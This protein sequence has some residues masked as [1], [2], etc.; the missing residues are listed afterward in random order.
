MPGR[1]ISRHRA[2][3]LDEC[4]I[5]SSKPAGKVVIGGRRLYGRIVRLCGRRGSEPGPALDVAEVVGQVAQAP[6]GAGGHVRVE[7]TG[8]D[9]LGKSV[10]IGGN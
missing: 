8:R 7:R 6:A 4:A 9:D 3:G 1:R 10:A 2:E 5:A